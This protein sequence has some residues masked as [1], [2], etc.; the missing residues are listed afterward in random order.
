MKKVG[1]RYV[2]QPSVFL[3]AFFDPKTS[4]HQLGRFKLIKTL[5]KSLHVL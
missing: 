5:L 3:D 4:L 2:R 1:C